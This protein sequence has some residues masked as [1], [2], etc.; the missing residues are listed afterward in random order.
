MT[1]RSYS[2]TTC[3]VGMVEVIIRMVAMMTLLE[4]WNY[5][6]GGELVMVMMALQN[7]E[8]DSEW[9]REG[10][11]DEGE[12]ENSES[13]TAN[14]KIMM[15]MMVVVVIIIIMDWELRTVRA[16]PWTWQL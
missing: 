9:E 5:F 3:N 2:W 7:L 1:A 13:P 4:H 10:Y 14:L 8:A 6:D 11:E 15:I 16:Q 12:G